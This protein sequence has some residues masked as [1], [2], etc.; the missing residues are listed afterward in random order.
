MKD[1]FF[2]TFEI[3]CGTENWSRQ[4]SGFYSGRFWASV[5]FGFM[6]MPFSVMVYLVREA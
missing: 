2:G 4:L 3:P 6:S 5:G 1:L